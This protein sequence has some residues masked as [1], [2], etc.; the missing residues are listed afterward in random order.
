MPVA[1][2]ILVALITCYVS[3]A[4]GIFE[5]T[6]GDGGILEVAKRAS[7]TSVSGRTS[8]GGSRSFSQDLAQAQ[9]AQA[10][11]PMLFGSGAGDQEGG[12]LNASAPMA[13]AAG[14]SAALDGRWQVD[15]G[16]G[17]WKDFD[18]AQQR[19]FNTAL[20][21]GLPKVDFTLMSQRY[22]LVFAEQVQRNLRSGKTRRVRCTATLGTGGAEPQAGPP[23]DAGA[24]ATEV[25]VAAVPGLQWQVQMDSGNWVDMSASDNSKINDAHA[26]GAA[27][28]YF[29]N[30]GQDYELNFVAGTQRNTKT[31][32]ERP[33]RSK[34][35]ATGPPRMPGGDIGGASS[36]VF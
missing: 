32:K 14:Q 9:I 1:L 13:A 23:P 12:Y 11:S 21:N 22:E 4:S 5:D 36:E 8:Q 3:W 34:P 28:A 19:D 24:P 15:M 7:L 30:R 25:A 17:N 2:L 18:E 33:V 27:C 6:K 29:H 10:P 26:K 16:N 35:T 31:G 20:V